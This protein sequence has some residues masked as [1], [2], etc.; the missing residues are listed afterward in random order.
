MR[1]EDLALAEIDP[2][3]ISPWKRLSDTALVPNPFVDPR[4]LLPSVNTH[5]Q[6]SQA[7]VMLIEDGDATIGALSYSPGVRTVGRL[8]LR[9]VSTS[10]SFTAFEGERFH[11]LIAP[12]RAEE[13]FGALIEGARSRGAHLLELARLPVRGGLSQA[14]LSAARARGVPVLTEAEHVF[15]CARPESMNTSEE[16]N[17]PFAFTH[18]PGSARKKLRRLARKLTNEH[19][20]L[21]LVDESQDQH[22]IERFLTL[23]KAGWKGDAVLDGKAF[24]TTGLGTWFRAVTEAFGRDRKLTVLT[25]RS[26]E[27]TVFTTVVLHAGS[28][29]FGFHDAYADEFGPYSPGALGRLAELRTLLSTKGVDLFDPNMDDVKYPQAVGL[30]PDRFHYVSYTLG[31]RGLGRLVTRHLPRARRLRDRLRPGRSPADGPPVLSGSASR[32]PRSG[33]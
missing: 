28:H 22:A 32:S 5:P 12:G 16:D 20:A 26:A 14:L 7:R 18:I 13:V 24:D 27:R 25:L 6:A 17:P 15:A 33:Q 10:D 30:Y 3:T 1:T 4:F 8:R 19:G 9:T 11:P 31:V 21:E 23:Q 2:K 29:G